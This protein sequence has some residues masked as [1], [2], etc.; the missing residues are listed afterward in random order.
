MHELT[1]AIDLVDRVCE[2]VDKEGALMATEVEITIGLLSGIDRI[3]FEFAFPEAARGTK[4]DGAKLV[5]HESN[6]HLFQFKSLEVKD[7]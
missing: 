3:S 5:I 6:D 7:V 2:I 4:A 1:L